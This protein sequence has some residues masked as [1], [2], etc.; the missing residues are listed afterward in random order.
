MAGVV[1]TEIGRTKTSSEGRIKEFLPTALTGAGD[2]GDGLVPAGTIGMSVT[3]TITAGTGSVQTTNSGVAA[4]QA[5]TATW[6]TWDLG[7]V[8]S[9]TV[10]EMA[11]TTA[12]RGV[13]GSGTVKLSVRYF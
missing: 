13:W 1:H 8:S 5:D 9:T 12:I 2:T 7:T 10:V 4:V 6:D 3:L 11:P